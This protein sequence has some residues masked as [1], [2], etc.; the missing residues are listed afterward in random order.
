MILGIWKKIKQGWGLRIKMGR[1]GV[2]TWALRQGLT[3]GDTECWEKGPGKCPKAGECLENSLRFKNTSMV[4]WH[5]VKC[6]SKWKP[7]MILGRSC[8]ALWKNE[9]LN[10]FPSEMGSYSSISRE[11]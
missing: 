2:F 9:I 4:G 7:L 5:G 11:P 8:I 6:S 3:G 10:F 1:G